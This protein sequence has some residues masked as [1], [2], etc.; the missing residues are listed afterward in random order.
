MNKGKI[1]SV[2]I[3][4]VLAAVI[5]FAFAVGIND[6]QRGVGAFAKSED[7]YPITAARMS[8]KKAVYFDSNESVEDF[9][10]R[11]T[12]VPETSQIESEENDEQETI[13]EDGSELCFDSARFVEESGEGE[14]EISFAPSFQSVQAQSE[15]ETDSKSEDGRAESLVFYGIWTGAYW[16]FTPDQIDAQWSGYKKSKP[17]LPQGTT[18]AWQSYLYERLAGIGAEWFYKYAVAQAMQ[19]SGFNP[20]NNIG[21][22]QISWI[23]GRE[24]YDCG[25][26]SFKD[27]YWNAAY[28]DV[29]D[30]HANINAYV[31]RVA[32]YLTDASEQGIYRAI[33][34]HYQPNG[35]MNMT[36]V[37]QVLG[38]LNELW[39]VQ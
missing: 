7:V 34:Q 3:C 12:E 2:L 21:R 8:A 1:L 17:S 20:L 9:T 16:H 35:Q 38:R 36:Y 26:F 11:E 24:T 19:E 32:P 23:G 30:Y 5:I 29:C 25:L 13:E 39:E 22:T 27:I 6:C 18:R 31:D 15:V 37:N 4:I 33:S 10:D 14:S 28:G